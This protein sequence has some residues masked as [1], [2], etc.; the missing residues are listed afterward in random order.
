[1]PRNSYRQFCPV[2]MATE[3]LGSRWTLLVVRELL[4]GSTRYNQLRMG[5]PRMSP[6]LLAKR[7]RELERAGVVERRRGREYRLTPAGEQLRGVVESAGAWG[8]HWIDARLTL[9]NLDA[10]LL[11]WDVRR[12]L[13]PSPLP[14]RRCVILFVYPGEPSARRRYWLIVE[15]GG[16]V[17]LCLVDPGHEVDLY[18]T[19]ELRA[20]TAVW[21]GLASLRRE[22]EARRVSLSGDR[23]LA[24]T[25]QRWL[26]YSP[27]AGERKRGDATVGGS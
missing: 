8:Q 14:R 20:M 22:I 23:A 13:D 25:M 9:D 1:M 2:A 18:V 19:A 4:E 26:G 21:L 12:N 15:A 24:R 5:V 27:F 16:E 11:M 6:A 10:K 3:I 17:D 7:L